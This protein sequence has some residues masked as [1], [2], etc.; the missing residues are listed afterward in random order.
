[1]QNTHNMTLRILGARGSIPVNGKETAQFGGSTSCYQ[2]EACGQ[3]IFLD[4]G[5]GLIN[6]RPEN[7]RISIL[8]SHTHI[9]H[10]LG[11]PFFAPMFSGQAEIDIYGAKR[12]DLTVKEQV[13]RFLSPP[14]WA[15]T[16]EAYPAK[17][18]FI[19]AVYP[20]QLG[21]VE[22]EELSGNHPGGA[23]ILKLSLDSVSVVYASD[24]EHTP[25]KQ[26]ELAEFAKGAALILYDGQYTEEEYLKRKGFGH[27]TVSEGLRLF[28][29]S[30]AKRLVFVHHDP[31]HSD[32]MLTNQEKELTAAGV[33]FAREGEIITL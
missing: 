25:G 30:G 7:D 16:I 3:T 24:Y 10:L 31:F 28:A 15:C 4:A 17:V 2:I 8:L 22:I 32:V 23:S 9:D 20:M 19:D 26:R 13:E 27:S 29:E 5:T 1:M 6:A 12:G 14:L 11:L 33:S 21:E 18:N